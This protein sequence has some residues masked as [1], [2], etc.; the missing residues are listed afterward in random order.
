[1]KTECLQAAK[2]RPDAFQLEAGEHVRIWAGRPEVKALLEDI[3]RTTLATSYSEFVFLYGEY[4]SGK[5]HSMRYLQHLISATQASQFKSLVIYVPTVLVADKPTFY[6]IYVYVITNLGRSFFERISKTIVDSFDKA[7]R[8][9]MDSLSPEETV[10]IVKEEPNVEEAVKKRLAKELSQRFPDLVSVFRKLATGDDTAWRFL[11][12]ENISETQAK[13][14]SLSQISR[15]DTDWAAF[16]T[17]SALFNILTLRSNSFEAFPIYNAIY[18][19]QDEWEEAYMRGAA[20]INS[21]EA[22]YRGLIDAC[23]TNLCLLVSYTGSAA[24]L[25]ATTAEKLQSRLTREPIYIGIM[26]FDSAYEF[27]RDY[28]SKFR[29]TKEATPE[30]PF[31]ADALKELINRTRPNERTPRILLRNC[32]LALEKACNEGAL[33][34]SRKITKKE[35]EKY[36]P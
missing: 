14:L 35:I 33:E 31:E 16:T 26:E 27:L 34:T 30:H 23:Q 7:V 8:R 3:V 18:L 15:I 17:L 6:D 22:G 10:S 19:F 2:L 25:S 32:R 29:T 11:A 12:G 24:A 4:G 13:T 28:F 1:M 9:K 36:F 5:T 21:L 20:T